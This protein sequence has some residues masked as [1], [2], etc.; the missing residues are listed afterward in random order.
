VYFKCK[1]PTREQ[2]ERALAKTVPA[3]SRE[4]VSKAA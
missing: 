4:G 3:A 2:Y 1:T